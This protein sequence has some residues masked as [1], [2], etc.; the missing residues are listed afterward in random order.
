MLAEPD[1]TI[2]ADDAIV[3]DRSGRTY[4]KTPA[5]AE[6]VWERLN[7]MFGDASFDDYGY[8]THDELAHNDTF[9]HLSNMVALVHTMSATPLFTPGAPRYEWWSSHENEVEAAVAHLAGVE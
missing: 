9:V 4:A 7:D 6:D 5:I 2:D 1:P 8:Y 3:T